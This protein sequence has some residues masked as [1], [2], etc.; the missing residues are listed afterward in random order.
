M[1]LF[2]S[3]SD[4]HLYRNR[5]TGKQISCSHCGGW[6]FEL[7]EAQLNTS[8]LT[9]ADLDFLNHSASALVCSNCGHIEWF[10]QGKDLEQ[11]D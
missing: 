1:G 8:L 5:R 9:A 3:S 11:L 4:T 7:R 10:Y 2:D 6:D